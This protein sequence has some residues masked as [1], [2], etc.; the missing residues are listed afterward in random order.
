MLCYTRWKWLL[1]ISSFGSGQIIRYGANANTQTLGS[2]YRDN[3]VLTQI[4]ALNIS[5][6]LRIES[7]PILHA[8]NII[9]LE[10]L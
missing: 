7:L 6:I 8:S 1:N 10:A 3:Q 5:L 4:A 2:K 9:I